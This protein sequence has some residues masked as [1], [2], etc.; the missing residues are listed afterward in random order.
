MRLRNS[1]APAAPSL[2]GPP[3][4]GQEST[5]VG[6]VLPFVVHAYGWVALSTGP[7]WG[8]ASADIFCRF[9]VCFAV[10]VKWKIPPGIFFWE[11][12]CSDRAPDANLIKLS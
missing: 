12:E 2:V 10:E 1:S 9:L 6:G 4:S 11:G 8:L 3:P 5:W 7:D